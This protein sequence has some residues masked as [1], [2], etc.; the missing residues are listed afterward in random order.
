MSFLS[1][2][3][4]HFSVTAYYTTTREEGPFS[5]EIVWDSGVGDLLDKPTLTPNG[6]LFFDLISVALS[7][8]SQGAEIRYTLDGSEPTEESSLSSGIITLT[9]SAVL[10]AKTFKT[11]MPPSST[12]LAPFSIYQRPRIH[13]DLVVLYTFDEGGGTQVTDTSNVAT[14][15]NLTIDN[16][17]KVSWVPG[18][19]QIIKPTMIYSQQEA[20]K[21]TRACRLSDE[22]SIEVWITPSNQQAIGKKSYRIVSLSKDN[23]NRNFMLA[24]KSTFF[25]GRIRTT[26]DFRGRPN[27]HTSQKSVAR[28]V[29]QLVYTR[30]ASGTTKIYID[31][32]EHARNFNGG[33]LSNWN[34]Q[35]HLVLGNLL[36]GNRPWLGTYHLL[37]I[38]N[39]ALP[40]NEVLSNFQQGLP[41]QQGN[42]EVALENTLRVDENLPRNRGE[43]LTNG[44]GSG[45][46]EEFGRL[47]VD[48]RNEVE[49]WTSNDLWEKASGK[50]ILDANPSTSWHGRVEDDWWWIVVG[51]DVPVQARDFQLHLTQESLSEAVVLSSSDGSEWVEFPSVSTDNGLFVKYFLIVFFSDG[52][53]MVP[54]VKE[55]VVSEH[56]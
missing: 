6:A 32:E 55:I 11:G 29:T 36:T 14:P 43:S 50:K 24:Q 22:I 18:A 10:K 44:N 3:P 41:S 49:V 47:R 34:E 28:E 54:E 48:W 51:Y 45:G 27:T 31:G 17:A 53:G 23:T 35:Y 9:E 46:R 1:A 38:Y 2:R 33:D 21:I 56:S 19:L 15:L 7:T 4:Y 20:T 40:S 26:T 8:E 25:Q 13:K 16:P 52:S 30:S 37:A 5:K 12:T 39:R 42:P